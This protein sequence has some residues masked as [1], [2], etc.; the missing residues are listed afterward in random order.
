MGLRSKDNVV[1]IA[2][3]GIDRYYS[4]VDS[5]KKVNSDQL[6][7]NLEKIFHKQNTDWVLELD[8]YHLERL[9]NQKYRDWTPR[10]YK[11]EY[12]EEMKSQEFWE[13]EYGRIEEIDREIEKIAEPLGK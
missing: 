3:D 13:K 8:H 10:G 1:T 6:Q 9:Y 4:V 11:R 5:L 12:L 2:T 7:K